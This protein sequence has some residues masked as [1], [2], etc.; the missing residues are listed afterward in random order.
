MISMVLTLVLK[1]K[2]QIFSVER[3]HRFYHIHSA[4]FFFRWKKCDLWNNYKNNFSAFFIRIYGFFRLI[5]KSC[6]FLCIVACKRDTD[7]FFSMPDFFPFFSHRDFSTLF[8]QFEK[9]CY[10]SIKMRFH[11]NKSRCFDIDT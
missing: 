6:R 10:I 2:R 8:F 1:H 9:K 4:W 7:I 11:T 5:A 3:K